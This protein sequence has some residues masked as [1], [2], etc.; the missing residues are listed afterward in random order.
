MNLKAFLF[1]QIAIDIVSCLFSKSPLFE[2]YWVNLLVIFKT[3]GTR[4]NIQKTRLTFT[5]V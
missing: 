1:C 5:Y 4:D 3:I 2:T